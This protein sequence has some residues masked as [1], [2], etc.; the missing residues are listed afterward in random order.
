M[1]TEF[2]PSPELKNAVLSALLQTKEERGEVPAA[3]VRDAVKVLGCSERTVWR[4]LQK[5]RAPT[6]TRERWEP[7]ESYRRLLLRHGGSIADLR[8]TLVD[9]GKEKVSARTMQRAFARE[10]AATYLTFT[11]QGFKAA[12]AML[13]TSAMPDLAIN[14]E[15]SMDDTQLPVWCI[16]PDGQVGK[17]QMQGIMDG[18]SRFILSLNVSPYIFDTED[19]VENLASA[20][21]GHYTENGV[22][23]GGKPRALR[24]DR[25]SIFVAEATSLGLVAEKIAR[26]YS[27]P[28]TP[29]QNGKIERWHRWK[30]VFKKLP[31]YDWSAFKQGD[32]RKAAVAPPADQLLTYAELV[33]AVAR[34]VHK[35]NTKRVHSAHKMTPQECWEHEVAANP[36]VVRRADG[37][38]LRAAMRQTGT[39]V[40]RRRR[41]DWE[42]RTYNV[43]PQSVQDPNEDAEVIKR[44]RRLIDAAEGKKVTFRFLHGRFDYVSVYNARNEYLGDAVWDK[45]QTV[46]QAGETAQTRRGHIKTMTLDLERIAKLDAEAVAANRARVVAELAAEGSDYRHYDDDNDEDA[47]VPAPGTPGDSSHRKSRTAK[48]KPVKR[49]A[50]SSTAPTPAQRAAEQRR[51][52]AADAANW[53]REQSA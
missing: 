25:G 26:K 11:R 46:A 20:M 35:Y 31:G 22:F 52:D 47:S 10:Y 37:V 41:I 44:R 36:D 39:R 50:G 27:H 12:D 28:Y 1:S 48:K 16:L 51:K 6:H 45:I 3:D 34:E 30:R 2:V 17:A 19:A 9:E 13:P 43:H 18:C 5:G 29:Q 15:W 38:A 49:K 33:I 21:A 40:L 23:I 7:N 32:P 4:W 42:T 14:D 24:T 8:E 53:S